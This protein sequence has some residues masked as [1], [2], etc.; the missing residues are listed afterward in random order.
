MIHLSRK[1]LHQVVEAIGDVVHAQGTDSSR[2]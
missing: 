2:R 1:G